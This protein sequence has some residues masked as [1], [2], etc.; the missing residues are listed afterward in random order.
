MPL[1]LLVVGYYGFLGVRYW[2]AYWQVSPL[3]ARLAVIPQ[4]GVP[5]ADALEADLKAQKQTLEGLKEVFASRRPD[6]FLTTISLLAQDAGV[7]VKSMTSGGRG[8]ATDGEMQYE[9]LGIT[10]SLDGEVTDIYKFL[11]SLAADLPVANIE[12]VGIDALEGPAS[13]TLDLVLYLSPQPV[14]EGS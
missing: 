14:E 1:T 13:A 9:T 7:Q 10:V 3:E 5:G 8:T 11:F 6:E 12:E 2:D 4:G